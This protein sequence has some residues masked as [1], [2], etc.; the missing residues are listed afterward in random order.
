M[1]SAYRSAAQYGDEIP[2]LATFISRLE[3][4]F[5]AEASAEQ[6]TRYFYNFNPVTAE[7]Q[8]TKSLIP[9][10]SFPMKTAELVGSQVKN[11][12]LLQLAIPGKVQQILSG[13][14]VEDR[15]TR[16]YLT[17]VLPD[18]KNWYEPLHG[19]IT[20][21]MRSMQ[22]EL[23]WCY[24][25]LS[26]MWNEDNRLHPIFQ[27]LTGAMA[28][29]HD[30]SELD[31]VTDNPTMSKII[32]Q[33]LDMAIPEPMRMAATL[34]A[35]NG[36]QFPGAD[37]LIKRYQERPPDPGQLRHPEKQMGVLRG[38]ISEDNP[39]GEPSDLEIQKSAVN[40]KFSDAVEFGKW[41]DKSY[42]DSWLYNMVFHGSLKADEPG[43][44]SDEQTAVRGEFVRQHIHDMSLGLVDMTKLDKTMFS[45]YF[46][47]DR[48]AKQA[49]Q[50]MLDEANKAM[51]LVDP[52]TALSPEA[53]MARAEEL[54]DP[55][56]KKVLALTDQKQAIT[57]YYDYI[58]GAQK[59]VPNFSLYRLLLGVDQLEMSSDGKP[60]PLVHQDLYPKNRDI[61]NEEASRVLNDAIIKKWYAPKAGG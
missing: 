1:F 49:K 19:G 22:I 13:K 29:K 37:F 30:G 33:N 43:L 27:L 26:A 54:G 57:A 59:K 36:V 5:T 25:T 52:K 34:A 9:F 14:Y 42:G 41:M 61:S 58:L 55:L 50:Q 16:D 44:Y 51:N 24:N 6:A 28:V 45:K 17:K 3:Q 53:I 18:M 56:A 10:I 46:A 15:E 12:D 11:G 7:Q 32:G 23:P 21:G 2:K 39:T 48:E 38:T 60:G 35:I 40:T 47:I 20:P 31:G 4:G 8:L